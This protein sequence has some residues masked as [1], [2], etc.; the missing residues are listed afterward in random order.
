MSDRFLIKKEG[1]VAWLIHN[2]PEALNA[3]LNEQWA[4]LNAT[5]DSIE[6]DPEMR[7]VVIAGEGRAFCAGADVKSMNQDIGI[8]SERQQSL[9]Q[10][11]ALQNGLQESTRRIRRSRLPYIAAIHGFAVGAGFELCM[12]CDLIVAERKTLMGFPE[13]NVGVDHHERRVLL[14]ATNT[15]PR[16]GEGD[17]L[18]RRIDRRRRSASAR[19]R[20]QDRGIRPGASGSRTSGQTHC[21]PCA[22]GG[23]IAQ[24]P[25][26]R[27]AR[28]QPRNN[29]ELRNGSHS[30]DGVL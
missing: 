25:V 10:L 14:R 4:A 28:V 2:R 30:H 9:N 15:G 24:A 7:V 13:V 5:I 12:A 16:K 3:M 19:L 1:H 26:G 11:R 23:D 17:G 18:H 29:A 22:G 6:S 8:F 27:R 21:Q 20:K